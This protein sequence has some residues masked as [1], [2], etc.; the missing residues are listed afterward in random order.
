MTRVVGR[1]TDLV[2]R[3]DDELA[4]GVAQ[5]TGLLIEGFTQPLQSQNAQRVLGHSYEPFWTLLRGK[6]CSQ[7]TPVSILHHQVIRLL[8]T[9]SNKPKGNQ[10]CAVLNKLSCIMFETWRCNK[11][12]ESRLGSPCQVV[13]SAQMPSREYGCWL[14]MEDRTT[15]L[16]R[17]LYA[18]KMQ[19]LQ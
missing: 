7:A 15:S 13:T 1:V 17:E 6:S 2:L 18:R 11:A 19:T 12:E 4:R 16:E 10:A 14:V 5:G 3:V 8:A 9:S